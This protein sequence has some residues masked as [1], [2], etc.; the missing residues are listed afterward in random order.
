MPVVGVMVEAEVTA[1]GRVPVGTVV[2]AGGR[3]GVMD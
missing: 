1:V 2:L 3:A